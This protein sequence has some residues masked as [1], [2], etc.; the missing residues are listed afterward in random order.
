MPGAIEHRKSSNST[1]NQEMRA[2][3]D[4][5]FA[6]TRTLGEPN[7]NT[8]TVGAAPPLAQPE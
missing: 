7:D 1:A 2:S 4:Y 3:F 8:F 6:S 5:K